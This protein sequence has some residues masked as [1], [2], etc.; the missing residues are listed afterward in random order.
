MWIYTYFTS[1]VSAIKLDSKIKNENGKVYLFMDCKDRNSPQN[2]SNL[3]NKPSMYALI[4][5]KK[6]K[7]NFSLSFFLW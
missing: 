5:T 3:H 1:G 2:V 6:A 7:E 4:K